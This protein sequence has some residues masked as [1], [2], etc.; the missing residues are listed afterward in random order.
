MLSKPEGLFLQLELY[1]L[2]AKLAG[3]QVNLE[4]PKPDRG[5]SAVQR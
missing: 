2:P 5:R 3:R 4:D 1:T